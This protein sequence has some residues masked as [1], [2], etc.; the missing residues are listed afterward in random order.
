MMKK[1]KWHG[2]V[3]GKEF[4]DRICK[5]LDDADIEYIREKVAHSKAT[6][7]TSKGKFDLVIDDLCL[8][9]KTTQAKSLD[10][11]LN[12]NKK[13]KIKWH[14]LANLYK[15]YFTYGKKAGLLLE[16]R[17]NKAIYI[18]VKDFFSWAIESKTKSLSYEN[19]LL[20]G[21]EIDSILDIIKGV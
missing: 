1:T 2:Q 13:A 10:Y 6:S 12:P 8:E 9:L 18:D 20:I 3:K 7:K 11:S 16:Y 14:Q 17:P 4:E 15:S 21:R 5:Q 19:A